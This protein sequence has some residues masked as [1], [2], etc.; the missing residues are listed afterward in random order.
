[1]A[2]VKLIGREKV[3]FTFDNNKPACNKSERQ[4]WWLLFVGFPFVLLRE[5]SGFSI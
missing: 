3:I 5:L 2:Y 1:M 4:V